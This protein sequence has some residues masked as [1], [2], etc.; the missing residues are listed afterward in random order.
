MPR[1]AILITT[2]MQAGAAPGVTSCTR[3]GGVHFEPGGHCVLR[4]TGAVGQVH[5]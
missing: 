3:G 1:E 5:L 4:G 2:S